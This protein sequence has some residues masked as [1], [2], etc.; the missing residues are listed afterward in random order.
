MSHHATIP[1]RLTGS[2]SP[3]RLIP[4]TVMRS[5]S[6][7]TSLFS[8]SF[9][10]LARALKWLLPLSAGFGSPAIAAEFKCP[11]PPAAQLDLKGIRPRYVAAQRKVQVVDDDALQQ[12]D[13]KLQNLRAFSLLASTLSD[14]AVAGS[15]PAADCLQRSLAKWATAGALLGAANSHQGRLERAWGLT[16]LSMVAF[17]LERSGFPL[18]DATTNWLVA[19]AR[20]VQAE[21]IANRRPSAANLTLWGTLGTGTVAL[22]AKDQKLWAWSSG[23]VGE[24]LDH[25]QRDGIA[26][27][28]L[29]RR[30]LATH[31]HF[32][33]A[34]P[35]LAFNRVARCYG[36]SLSP[37]RRAS[38]QRFLK[39]LRD[40]KARKTTLDGRAGVKQKPEKVQLWFDLLDRPEKVSSNRDQRVPR[41]GGSIRAFLKAANC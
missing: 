36:H 31:Y 17:K 34:Q 12:N 28:E 3:N 29:R 16:T 22:I 39:L 40:L 30:E 1:S 21:E 14:Q 9:S 23:E 10:P 25:I 15:A 18:P 41:L 27:T 26:P 7:M 4:P 33:A 5:L 37:A 20:K 11:A 8:G 2:R 6:C 24:F 13:A 35:L 32:Y 19:V 38:M